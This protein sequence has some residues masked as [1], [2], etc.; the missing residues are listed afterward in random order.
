MSF[1]VKIVYNEIVPQKGHSVKRKWTGKMYFKEIN[2]CEAVLYITDDA[3]TAKRLKRAGEAVLIY[4]H[5]GNKDQDFSEF[6]FAVENPEDLDAEYVEKVWKRLKGLPWDIME[7]KRC[8]IRET[9][10]EDVEHFYRIYSEPSITKYMEGLYPDVE[11]EKQY[12]RDYI[13]K[14]YTFFEFGVWTVVEK[15]SGEIIG[16]AGI[17]YREGYEIPELGFVIGVPWQRKGYAKEVCSAVLDYARKVFGFEKIQA[18]VEPENGAS[19]ELC[20]KLGMYPIE[21]VTLADKEY[22]RLMN[23]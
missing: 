15:E 21:K 10:T 19:L 18:L 16:R 9:T 11:E 22:I 8:L 3:A 14:V 23:R 17:S 13:E 1:L 5:E 7:T 12:I 6:I 4:L 20:A 2:L